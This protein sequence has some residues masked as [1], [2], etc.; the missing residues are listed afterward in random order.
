MTATIERIKN[1]LPQALKLYA[2]YNKSAAIKS[3]ITSSKHHRTPTFPNSLPPRSESLH[4]IRTT[5]AIMTAG[6]VA[7][8]ATLPMVGYPIMVAAFLVPQYSLS[9]HFWTGKIY[10]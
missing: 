4:I 6:P 8:L 1:F 9:H 2:D 3:A 5:E 10:T 7:M